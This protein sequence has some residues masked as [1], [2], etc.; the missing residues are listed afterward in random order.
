MTPAEF[1]ALKATER[2]CAE[3]AKR[4][5]AL[6]EAQPKKRKLRIAKNQRAGL[7][8][9]KASVPKDNNI[10]SQNGSVLPV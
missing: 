8:P 6:E 2:L 3:L 10:V 5:S 9:E 4:V 1:R 7:L